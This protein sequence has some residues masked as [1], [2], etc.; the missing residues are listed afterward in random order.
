MESITN[1]G[2]I[3]MKLNVLRFTHEDISLTYKEVEKFRGFY[4]NKFREVQEMH[5]HTDL[6]L[7]YGYPL[8]QYKLLGGK[9]TI[10]GVGR[11]CDVLNANG[12]LLEDT[13]K[14]GYKVI[15]S[16]A[17]MLKCSEEDYG[18]AE[19]MIE[20]EFET[21]YVPLNQDSYKE[22]KDSSLLELHN[23]LSSKIVGNI[24][25]MSKGLGYQVDSKLVVEHRL[26]PFKIIEV[27]GTKFQTFKGTFKVNFNIPD[28]L[29]IGKQ[30]SKGFGSVKKVH[31]C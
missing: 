10:I 20:Y 4:A 22:F 8:V 26:K 16:E 1:I 19:N 28:G 29:G 14:I 25:S 6:G 15:V 9:P 24:I 21:A 3:N 12:V 17:Q 31:N 5:N 13:L 11:G 7:K 18:V 30:V 2:D 23:T 27:K